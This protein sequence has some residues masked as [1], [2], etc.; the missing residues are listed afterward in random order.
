MLEARREAKGTLSV[1]V[2]RVNSNKAYTSK[3][4][5]GM[6]RPSV[7][8]FY[9]IVNALRLHVDIVQPIGQNVALV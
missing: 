4:E 3:I 7:S 2:Q 8:V 5:R 6:V 1:L 9:R